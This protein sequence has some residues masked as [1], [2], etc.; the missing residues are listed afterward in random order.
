MIMR[1]YAQ[2]NPQFWMSEGGRRL[3]KFGPE[4]LLVA[5]YLETSPHSNMLGLY[6]IPKLY[7]AHE[8]GLG[9]EGASKGLQGCIEAEFCRFDEASEVVWVIDMALRQIAPSLKE[10]DKRTKNV[11]QAYASLPENP[12]LTEFYDR[13]S[14][15]FHL[16]ERRVPRAGNASKTEGASKPLRSQEQEQEQEAPSQEGRK[17]RDGRAQASCTRTPAPTREAGPISLNGA[18]R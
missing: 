11:Q 2:V 7:L 14:P 15:A 8:T 13:Y 10:T 16:L 1:S 17:P 9:I 6:Y 3:R 12:F 5:V 4:A 18:A